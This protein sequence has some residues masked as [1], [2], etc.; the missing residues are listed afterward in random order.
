MDNKFIYLV[1]PLLLVS[2]II[3]NF[4]L[5]KIFSY[6]KVI[7]ITLLFP[8]KELL[9]IPL[10]IFLTP[11]STIITWFILNLLGYEAYTKGQEIF[12]GS[13]GVDIT[14]GCS[15]SEQIIFAISSMFVLNL[16]IPFKNL[17]VFYSQLVISCL[18]TFFV[19]VFRL[20]ILAVFV[21][22]YQSNPFSVFDFFHG[23]NGSLIFALIST[24]LCCE[25]YKRLY[26][27][28][29]LNY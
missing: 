22:T 25:F 12:I 26:T 4:S 7:F 16:L 11:L 21:D 13:G 15:G 23:S 1:L 10:S 18:I 24:A 27:V 8:I 5:S 17:Y 28:D 6:Y 2:L 3:L 14:F 19:N 29:K 20:C 9:F